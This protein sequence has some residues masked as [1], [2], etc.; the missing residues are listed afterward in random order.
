[1]IHSLQGEE[2]IYSIALGRVMIA[3]GLGFQ[4]VSSSFSLFFFEAELFLGQGLTVV[5][6][7]NVPTTSQTHPGLKGIA[8][9]QGDSHCVITGGTDL[10]WAGQELRNQSAQSRMG[11][12]AHMSFSLLTSFQ[13][14][15][16]QHQRSF[17]YPNPTKME[18]S[19]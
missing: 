7:P 6:L 17:H 14:T 10:S 16:Q 3:V 8:F 15:V 5:C 12:V 4:F 19:R 18:L 13:S 2:V 11:V 9:F 1:L